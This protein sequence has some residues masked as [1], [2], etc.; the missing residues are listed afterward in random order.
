MSATTIAAE[1]VLNLVRPGRYFAVWREGSKMEYVAVE[2]GEALAVLPGMTL[3][4]VEVKAG[5]LNGVQPPQ[6]VAQHPRVKWL[7]E[8]V[9]YPPALRVFQYVFT[10]LKLRLIQRL[11]TGVEFYMTTQEQDAPPI[12]VHTVNAYYVAYRSNSGRLYSEVRGGAR[13]Y[14][15]VESGKLK[16]PQIYIMKLDKHRYEFGVRVPLDVD[17]VRQLISYLTRP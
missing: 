2:P 5:P 13:A 1:D 14:Q 12:V 9:G 8:A 15:L 7:A 4:V 16:T 6:D 10:P 17:Q 3:R 11:E